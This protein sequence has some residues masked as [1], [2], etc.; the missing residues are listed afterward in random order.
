MWQDVLRARALAE[1]IF[2][3][4]TADGNRSLPSGKPLLHRM[5]A[6]IREDHSLQNRFFVLTRAEQRIIERT[7]NFVKKVVPSALVLLDT[8]GMAPFVKAIACFQYSVAVT[9][10]GAV[11]STFGAA[12]DS[13]F[14]DGNRRSALEHLVRNA[15]GCPA[16]D[17]GCGRQFQAESSLARV[18]DR[19]NESSF[20]KLV[21]FVCQQTGLTG[22]PGE[23]GRPPFQLLLWL[24]GG[25]TRQVELLFKELLT[26]E[27]AHNAFVKGT[28]RLVLAATVLT[29]AE[30]LVQAILGLL[31]STANQ[32]GKT[33][34]KS[35]TV[36]L[37]YVITLNE[38]DDT[39]WNL[40]IAA[41][42]PAP[43]HDQV[44][45]VI[46]T[47]VIAAVRIASIC[48]VRQNLTS[49][50]PA[51]IVQNVR[52][53]FAAFPLISIHELAKAAAAVITPVR[54][55]VVPADLAVDTVS[56]VNSFF[57]S[58][59]Q[60]GNGI[61]ADSLSEQDIT[62]FVA[63]ITLHGHEV[64]NSLTGQEMLSAVF[65]GLS[66]ELITIRTALRCEQSQQLA[67]CAE[68]FSEEK[69]GDDRVDQQM[70]ILDDQ[71]LSIYTDCWRW[72]S[73]A[74]DFTEA[75]I[76]AEL[77]QRTTHNGKLLAVYRN[78]SL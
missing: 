10:L 29:G 5:V 14:L 56:A 61:D 37:N 19:T 49:D 2:L 48:E 68:T 63:K 28:D 55:G 32:I 45:A 70:R 8:N 23:D 64:C 27:S 78:F 53:L 47:L 51:T 9:V 54:L 52:K 71:I 73:T 16:V 13:L 34:E 42:P 43:Q 4:Q 41:R 58:P 24:K 66:R 67:R 74:L 22:V 44:E 31:E 33:T 65:R 39:L 11:F 46:R 15:R 50:Q 6:G 38:D 77:L 26:F 30:H 7:V 20:Q 1:E 40:R 25:N 76:Q 69:D 59:Q 17:E 35:H 3:P 21:T 60:T 12:E 57:A 18:Y 72:L 62:A 36:S 75:R